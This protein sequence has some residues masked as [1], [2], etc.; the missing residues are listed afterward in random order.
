[1]T[2]GKIGGGFL[3][4]VVALL[5]AGA[6]LKDACKW[7][8]SW[9]LPSWC[10]ECYQA[11][12]RVVMH[13]VECGTFLRGLV[14]EVTE[15]P[16]DFQNPQGT[17][18][19]D[20][21]KEENAI[22]TEKGILDGLTASGFAEKLKAFPGLGEHGATLLQLAEEG[23]GFHANKGELSKM[24]PMILELQKNVHE[25][26]MVTKGN[27]YQPSSLWKRVVG[28]KS[29]GK[30]IRSMKQFAP[31]TDDGELIQQLDVV[32][33]LLHELHTNPQSD[34]Q[35]VLHTISRAMGYELEAEDLKDLNTPVQWVHDLMK[36]IMPLLPSVLGGQKAEEL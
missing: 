33:Q 6:P 19:L 17:T 14:D 13:P 28:R 32:T 24:V 8:P 3:L 15:T 23:L 1:M 18:D 27:K 25:H 26:Y 9:H 4:C 5:H 11:G 30:V 35:D 22:S 10:T 2:A 12:C 21:S 36:K 31:D 34:M 20:A 16:K 7:E 29:Q